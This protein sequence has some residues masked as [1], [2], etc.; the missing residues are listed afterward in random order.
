MRAG[1]RRRFLQGSAALASLSLMAGCGMLR[2][3]GQPPARAARIGFLAPDTPESNPTS[4]TMNEAFRE[5]LLDLGYVEGQT[6]TIEWKLAE[7]GDALMPAFAADL[8][9]SQPDV[10]V[11][12]S[13]IAA[14]AA[15]AA[16]STIP[17]VIAVAS[18]PVRAGLVAS[19]ARPG[20]TSPGWSTSARC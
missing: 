6:I 9:R 13:E 11:V 12:R 3:T 14:R 7:N 17:I 4:A 19:L 20:G 10:I 5:A 2:A 16:T 8:V 1:S 18:D 15:G